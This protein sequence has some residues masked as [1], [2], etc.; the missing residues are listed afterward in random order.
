MPFQLTTLISDKTVPHI[1]LGDNDVVLGTCLN[2]DSYN[3]II[4][5]TAAVN[6]TT[7]EIINNNYDPVILLEFKN[8]E[9]VK[10]LKELVDSVYE[11]L[12]EIVND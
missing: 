4:T 1:I 10:V 11:E 8:L 6:H 5:F 7:E 9:A 12:S 2:G 3:K